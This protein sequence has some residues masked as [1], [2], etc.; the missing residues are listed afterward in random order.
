MSQFGGHFEVANAA[1][2]NGVVSPHLVTFP[3]Q[4][5]GNVIV[6]VD[7]ANEGPKNEPSTLFLFLLGV[8][9]M[10]ALKPPHKKKMFAATAPT[11]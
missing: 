3:E 5:F 8:S 10:R 6:P 4:S 11:R 7:L 9:H 1:S 2:I